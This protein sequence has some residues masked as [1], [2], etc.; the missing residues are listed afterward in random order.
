MLFHIAHNVLQLFAM[1]TYDHMDMTGH[2]A[3]SIYFKAFLLPAVF[4]RIQHDISVFITNE[5]VYPV[6][7]GKSYKIK[8]VLVSEFIFDTHYSLKVQ[9]KAASNKHLASCSNP[10][11]EHGHEYSARRPGAAYSRQVRARF[12]KLP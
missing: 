2:D 9:K 11:L 5:N 1:R 3:P 7:Y 8:L 4:P 6:Y 10:G 12:G